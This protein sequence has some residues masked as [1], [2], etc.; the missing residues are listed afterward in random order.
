MV[1][2]A[3]ERIALTNSR[4]LGGRLAV[5]N[6][7]EVDYLIAMNLAAGRRYR[8]VQQVGISPLKLNAEGLETAIRFAENPDVDVYLA[9][10]IPMAGTTCPLDPRSALV[11]ADA[12]QLAFEMLCSA[13][14]PT[15]GSEIRVEP[16][17]FQYSTIV[18]GS[19]EWC[20]YRALALQMSAYLNGQPE[21][22]GR[23]RSVA[24]RLTP[25]LH[26]SEPQPF[27]GRHS[28]G[29][30]ILAVWDNC[31][32]MRSSAPNKRFWIGRF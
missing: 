13:L 22:S 6:P 17:D 30:G 2:L 16:F 24:K 26:A 14:F 12:E 3:A 5:T 8:L 9:G 18:F 21:H 32:L 28:W 11:Q 27:S 1:P 10:Y 29:Y 7:V 15:Q 31:R 23:F 4:H 19:P 25:R 20:L